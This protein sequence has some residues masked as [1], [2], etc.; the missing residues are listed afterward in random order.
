MV[1]RFRSTPRF[2]LLPALAGSDRQEQSMT[3][4]KK[5]WGGRFAGGQDPSFAEFNKSFG[6]DRRLFA[7]DIRASV[8]HCNALTAA[9]VLKAGEAEKIKAAL[10]KILERGEADSCYFDELNSEDVHSFVEARLVELVGEV[11]GK[12]HTGRSRNDQV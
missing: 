1:G 7:V 9:D 4:D 11:G 10:Q 6:F 8:A 2:M 5:L 3:T 12:L